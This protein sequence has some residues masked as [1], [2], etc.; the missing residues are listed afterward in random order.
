V[1]YISNN[2]EFF[3]YI[4]ASFAAGELWGPCK[5]GISHDPSHRV[6]E[7]QRATFE[8]LRLAKIFK[9]P[10]QEIA[11]EVERCV[12]FL[13]RKKRIRG[14]WF[15]LSPQFAADFVELVISWWLDFFTDLN[16]EQKLCVLETSKVNRGFHK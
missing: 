12:H 10:N 13:Q 7:L 1:G 6:E 4:A 5:I 15:D 2:T 3:L 8:D 9:F 11:R 16:Q 14:E